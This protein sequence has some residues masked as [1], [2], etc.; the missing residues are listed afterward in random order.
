MGAAPAN[1]VT[2]TKNAACLQA[3]SGTTERRFRQPY[4]IN[5]KNRFA[6]PAAGSC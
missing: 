2:L 3:A 1:R 5:R 4:S 6:D